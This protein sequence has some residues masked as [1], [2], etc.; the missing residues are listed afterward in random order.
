MNFTLSADKETI[1]RTRDYALKHGSSLNQ[2]VRDFLNNLVSV[3]DRDEAADEFARNA[4]EHPGL[5]PEGFRFDREA[6]HR[7]SE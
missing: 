6:A 7:R 2:L 5:S 3:Q 1:E 4:A